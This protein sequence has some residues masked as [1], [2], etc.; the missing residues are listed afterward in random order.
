MPLSPPQDRE[1][2]HHR[3]ISVKGYKRADGLFEVEGTLED[4]KSYDFKLMSGVR[5]AGEPVHR[6]WLR[7]TYDPTLTIVDAEAAS[8]AHPYPG[9][10]GE[11]V[12]KYRSLIGV[13]MRPGFSAIVRERFGGTAGCTHLT[14]LI[15]TLATTAF[16]TLAG[17]LPSDPTRKPFQLDR[18]HAL[19][20]KSDAV[21]KF[22]PKWY[23]GSNHAAVEVG[24]NPPAERDSGNP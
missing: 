12:P 14:D 2:L 10:C 4:S 3:N 15:A 24:V 9:V 6:M 19:D 13:S 5:Y 8:D 22:Y 21:A 20:T 11:I 16:Q 17:Q 1:Q 7:L 23:T 18:C